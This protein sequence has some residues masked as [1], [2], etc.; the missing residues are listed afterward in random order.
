MILSKLVNTTTNNRVN[1]HLENLRRYKK[2]I[3]NSS[4]YHRLK[5]ATMEEDFRALQ[6]INHHDMELLILT[7]VGPDIAAQAKPEICISEYNLE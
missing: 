4:K 3:F 7:K 6:G 1:E 2:Y 5:R